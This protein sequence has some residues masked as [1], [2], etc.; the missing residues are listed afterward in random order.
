MRTS[1]PILIA[2]AMLFVGQLFAQTAQQFKALVS[3]GSVVEL[4]PTDAAD[5][6][7]AALGDKKR[8][9]FTWFVVSR[10][11]KHL[12]FG[13]KCSDL[14]ACGRTDKSGWT[15]HGN[16]WIT[17]ECQ[18]GCDLRRLPPEQD[19]CYATL[20][21]KHHGFELY[22]SIPEQVGGKPKLSW[23]KVISMFSEIPS[24]PS[25]PTTNE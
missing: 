10:S 4:R 23:W 16:F 3:D 1:I 9:T 7:T 21:R 5:I 12:V 13:I 17:G 20:E 15:Y 19:W 11:E 24:A 22:I 6:L 25:T 14:H 2:I 18:V 8:D